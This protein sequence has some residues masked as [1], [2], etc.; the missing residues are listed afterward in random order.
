MNALNY[1]YKNRYLLLVALLG[2][3]L[4]CYSAMSPV[5]SR[6][7]DATQYKPQDILQ[8]RLLDK[9]KFPNQE[10]QQALLAAVMPEV[11]GWFKTEINQF[12]DSLK[13]EERLRK[14][15][16]EVRTTIAPTPFFA[17]PRETRGAKSEPHKEQAAYLPPNPM[18]SLSEVEKR[19]Q[20]LGEKIE[21]AALGQD[22][23]EEQEQ[24]E[25][26]PLANFAYL[27]Q[28][29]EPWEFVKGEKRIDI[30]FENAELINFI[31]YIEKQYEL[32]FILDDVIKP[33][34]PGARQVTGVKFT[35]KT[36]QP[37]NKKQAWDIFVKFLDMAGLMIIPGPAERVYLITNN[38]RSSTFSTSKDPLPTFIGV[39]YS[40]LP[41]SDV[42]IRYVYFIQNTTPNVIKT[43]ADNLK[44]TIAGQ[45]ILIEDLNALIL[46]D[47]ATN[48]RS[49]LAILKELD[50]PVLPE[51][52]TIIKLQNADASKVKGL[53][54]ALVKEETSLLAR[55]GGGGRRQSSISYFTENVRVIADQ[56]TNSLIILGPRVN[57]EKIELFVRKE[58]DKEI[59]LPYSPLHVYP[60]KYIDAEATA[61]IVNELKG[62]NPESAA[63]A[64]QFGGVI[65]GTKFLKPTVTITAEKSTN[66]LIINADYDDYLQIYDLLQKIDTEQPQ[67]AMRILVINVD[68]QDNRAF[69]MQ[70]RNRVPTMNGILSPNS[71]TAVGINGATV[72]VPDISFQ[73]SGLPLGGANDSTIV[74]N[75]STGPPAFGG[76]VRL[77]GNLINLASSNTPGSTLVTLGS[78]AF[79]VWGL[80]KVL[81]SYLNASVVAKPFL[82]TTNKYAAQINISEIRRVI[83][84]N[85]VGGSNVS[86]PTFGDLQAGLDINVTPQISPDGLITLT[87]T[88]DNSTF[89]TPSNNAA[90]PSTSPSQGNRT[91]KSITTSVIVEDDQVL[92]LGGL[93]QD[94]MSEVEYK[95][96]ILGDVPILGWFFKSKR[97]FVEKQSLLILVSAEII[98]PYA[99]TRIE[100]FTNTQMTSA[101]SLLD[102]M[103]CDEQ[104][105][106]PIHTWFFE[107]DRDDIGTLMRNFDTNTSPSERAHKKP[108][109]PQPRRMRERARRERARRQFSDNQ[110][111]DIAPSGPPPNESWTSIQEPPPASQP[112]RRARGRRREN[113]RAPAPKTDLPLCA[114]APASDPA[115]DARHETSS[116]TWKQPT[117]AVGPEENM[118]EQSSFDRPD[119]LIEAAAAYS[120]SDYTR[121][122]VPMGT[123]A[124]TN[125]DINNDTPTRTQTPLHTI[126]TRNKSLRDFIPDRASGVRP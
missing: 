117:C 118:P 63:G 111:P 11:R 91:D 39:D 13:I 82:V 73:T 35:F 15:D 96:P 92:A 120:R 7:A 80:F 29:L 42:K 59:D 113:K 30:N 116:R 8:D 19:L 36:E 115:Y 105:K 108:E 46:A 21:D 109:Q 10:A 47:R 22:D 48:I 70:F 28:F 106:D 119:R 112:P 75:P 41:T 61:Q 33:P 37:L 6:V 45:P 1:A 97:K 103:M 18:E 24:A 83:T 85:I 27:G 57:V 4:T 77:L 55:L 72:G 87:I 58:I 125:K 81:Q 89:T 51:T 44:S 52:L 100:S 3:R 123:P 14:I 86:V 64:T 23:V 32:T 121:A 69:G 98:N 2:I 31:R 20:S 60:L 53:Y 17:I 5:D 56:R 90:T 101:Q 94:T 110:G 12:L 114:V 49:I 26:K 67:V 9:Q 40:L 65:G 79:G 50:K 16:R 66:S 74:T 88:V 54:D 102:T 126:K 99:R 122:P 62:F 124:Y 76:P 43:V 34:E 68:F 95:V 78:D 71:T 25:E 93:T 38:A 107:D 84:S 104:L